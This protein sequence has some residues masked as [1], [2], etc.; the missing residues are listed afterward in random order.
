MMETFRQWKNERGVLEL[1]GRYCGINNFFDWSFELNGCQIPASGSSL[2]NCLYI[3]ALKAMENLKEPAGDSQSD[4]A[5]EIH[6]MQTAT[7]H[8]FYDKE[9]KILRDCREYV[10]NQQDLDLCGVP[11]QG[12]TEIRS[13][14]IAHALALLADVGSGKSDK[15]I[16][17]KN[18]ISEENFAPELFYGSF[19]QLAMKKQG[20]HREALDYIRHWWGPI[21]DSGSSTLWENGVYSAGK[22]GFGGSA[23]LCHGF[24]SSPVDFLQTVLLGIAPL[25]PGF[26]EF[27]F[28]P[29]PCGLS[30]AHGCIPTPH[31]TIRVRWKMQKG[32]IRASLL[33][34]VNT[35]AH[36]PSGKFGPGNHEFSWTQNS[37]LY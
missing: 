31:G 6:S 27:R 14:R 5:G 24:S 35:L 8:E 15:E 30:F 17:E 4:F 28:D 1:P 11:N 22:A 16:L 26:A 36:T 34:P 32:V 2:M 18:L 9:K 20:L 10:V 37:G 29:V 13:S 25:R 23:S 7:W 12:R 3:I 19:L 21:L 33:V